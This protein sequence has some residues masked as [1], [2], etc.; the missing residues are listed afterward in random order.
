MSDTPDPDLKVVQ[1]PAAKNEMMAAGDSLRRN[2][3][4]MVAN[5]VTI[6]KFRRASYLAHLAEGFDEKQSLELCCK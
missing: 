4:V 2:F 5:T 1:M 3:D 6:A